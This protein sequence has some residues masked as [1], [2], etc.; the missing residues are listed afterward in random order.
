MR[1]IHGLFELVA[2]LGP[3]VVLAGGTRRSR[4]SQRMYVLAEIPSIVVRKLEEFSSSMPPFSRM[5]WKALILP[6][7]IGDSRGNVPNTAVLR[8]RF[9]HKLDADQ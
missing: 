9:I 6:L 7:N 1:L 3:L 2:H 8:I 4:W 5:R